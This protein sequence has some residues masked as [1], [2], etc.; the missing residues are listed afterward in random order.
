MFANAY[1][2]SAL[3]RMLAEAGFGKPDV[4]PLAPSPQ[5]LVVAQ[6]A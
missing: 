1:P 4:T 3:T 2:A 5:S 6:A